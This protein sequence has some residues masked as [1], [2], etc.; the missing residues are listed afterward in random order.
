MPRDRKQL[1]ERCPKC[2][3]G[4]LT[5]TVNKYESEEEWIVSWEHRCRDC[6][7]RDTKAYRSSDDPVE[8]EDVTRVCPF[9]S[10]MAL[11]ES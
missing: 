10:R 3:D 7:H 9:C 1:S 11:E 8:S 2:G 4:A 5:C 6:S